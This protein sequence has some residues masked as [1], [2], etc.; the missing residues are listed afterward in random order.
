MAFTI[1]DKKEMNME[2]FLKKIV[3]L[4]MI[5]PAVYLALAWKKI[6]ETVAMHFD[7]KGEA[8]RYGNKKELITML[9]VLMVVNAGV[10]L[11]L[12]NIYRID[13]KK[14]AV[15]NKSRLNRMAFAV[16]VFMSAVLCL[17]L[18][19]SLQ[20]NIKFSM[21]FILAGIGLLFAIMG[22]YMH[23]I[24]PNYFAG[25]RL[26]WTLEN[27]EN[28]KKTHAMAGK[29]WFFG[30]LLAAV[31]CLLMPSAQAALV[32]FFAITITMT[33]IPIVYSYRLFRKQKRSG[34]S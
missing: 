23:N 20:S 29:L 9:I 4:V 13:P 16:S 14:Y 22:N 10:Y 28:W 24:K 6:P 30:G 18:F 12:T 3:W 8:D 33:I 7:W 25:F 1:Q 26:P 15:E 2:R 31:V 27:E 11:L 34:S 32:A 5:I 19:S 21:R 17:L